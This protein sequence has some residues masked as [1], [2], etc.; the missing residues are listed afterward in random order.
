[1]ISKAGVVK[2]PTYDDS[3][4]MGLCLPKKKIFKSTFYLKILYKNFCP[5]GRLKLARLLALWNTRRNSTRSQHDYRAWLNQ[6]GLT[7]E[8]GLTGM[9]VVSVFLSSRYET[10]LFGGGGLQCLHSL[11]YNFSF[12]PHLTRGSEC[13]S[14]G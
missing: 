9:V 5:K 8:P 14:A 13:Y 3:S 10:P 7:T 2:Q 1:M 6:D 12:V 11:W 4:T